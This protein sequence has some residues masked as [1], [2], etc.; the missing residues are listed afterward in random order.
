MSGDDEDDSF[1][2][3]DQ[4]ESP[5]PRAQLD[6]DARHRAFI[7]DA[8]VR[9][10]HAPRPAPA[11][12]PEPEKPRRRIRPGLIAAVLSVTAIGGAASWFA[13]NRHS[14]VRP[15]GTGE[16]MLDIQPGSGAGAEILLDG[17]PVDAGKLDAIPVSCDLAHHLVV[18]RTGFEAYSKSFYL[19]PPEK[20]GSGKL[21]IPIDLVPGRFGRLS[22][23]TDVPAS[24]EISGDAGTWKKTAPFRDLKLPPGKYTLRL[25]GPGILGKSRQ[26][27][28]DLAEGQPVLVGEKFEE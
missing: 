11:L 9:L 24:V 4:T 3:L 15:P 13:L 25:K 22:V 18:K 17:Q 16:L 20:G 10:A 14:W 8:P 12:P 1:P 2:E 5:P 7:E 19:N 27:A 23:S 6:L 28:I 26:L 21:L